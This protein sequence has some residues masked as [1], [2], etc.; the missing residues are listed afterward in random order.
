MGRHK[1]AEGRARRLE[2]LDYLKDYRTRQG[3]W[4]TREQ[5]GKDLGLSM[6][7][8][9]HHTESLRVQKFIDWEPGKWA[10]TLRLTRKQRKYLE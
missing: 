9:L 3:Y 4:P 8:L 6:G 5:T 2:I 7:V 10:H 1:T